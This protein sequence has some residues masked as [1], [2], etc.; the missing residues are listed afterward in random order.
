[1]LEAR[2]KCK[3]EFLMGRDLMPVIRGTL[4][5]LHGEL[6]K[7]IDTKVTKNTRFLI[8]F[9]SDVASNL[10]QIFALNRS[11]FKGPNRRKENGAWFSSEHGP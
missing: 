3:V 10:G 6:Q 8:K 5:N 11:R 2:E 4:A 9:G 7:Q 1:M